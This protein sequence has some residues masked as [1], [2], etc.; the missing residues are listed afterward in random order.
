MQKLPF[1]VLATLLKLAT[2]VSATH[3]ATG[4]FTAV[5]L[6]VAG[7]PEDLNGNGEGDKKANSITIGQ[8]FAQYD[9]DIINVQE[10][11]NYHAYI[12]NN[13]DHPYRTPTSGGVPFGSGLNTLSTIRFKDLVRVDWEECD[14]NEGDCLIPKG[15]TVVTL[16]LPGGYELDVFN[17][18]MDAGSDAG[19]STARTSNF[20]QV[21]QA[22]ASRSDPAGRAVIVMGDTNSRY[23]RPKDNLLSFLSQTELTDTWVQLVRGG[24]APASTDPALVCASPIPH[25]TNCEIVDKVL[26]KNGKDVTLT[27]SNWQYLGMQ[28]TNATGAPLSDHTPIFVDFSYTVA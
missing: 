25:T 4:S 28:F 2:I 14:P 24:K 16:V 10:D 15:Y 22:I 3:I 20:N 26:Y 6:N 18:H 11:F 8:K 13:D 5:T 27:P 21:A 17:L 23:T 12:Y 9:F 7:L 1:L 19:D